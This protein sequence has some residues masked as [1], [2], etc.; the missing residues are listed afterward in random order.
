MN[1]LE[2]IRRNYNFSKILKED[3]KQIKDQG[4]FDNDKIRSNL[5]TLSNFWKSR[6]L[7]ECFGKSYNIGNP[8]AWRFKSG[9]KYHW[10]AEEIQ[11]T[12]KIGKASIENCG[13]N[14]NPERPIYFYPLAADCRIKCDFYVFW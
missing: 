12:C 5:P 3:L 14:I 11:K 4:E 9:N 2:E 7:E 10:V 13:N 6:N 1:I 8:I